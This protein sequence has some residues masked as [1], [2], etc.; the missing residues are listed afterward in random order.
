MTGSILFLAGT[1]LFTPDVPLSA[2]PK[3]GPLAVDFQFGSFGT[4]LWGQQYYITGGALPSPPDSSLFLG[5]S[6]VSH[7]REYKYRKV[8]RA[9]RHASRVNFTQRPPRAEYRES[10]KSADYYYDSRLCPLL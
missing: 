7:S 3:P 1:V 8:Y 9:R 2:A 6:I 10:Y 5:V 4:L